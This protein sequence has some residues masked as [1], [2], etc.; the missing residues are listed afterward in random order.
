MNTIY[1]VSIIIVNYNTCQLLE[2]CISSIYRH[3]RNLNYE[4]IVVDNASTDDSI[5]MIQREFPEVKLISSPTNLGFGQANNLGVKQSQGK[6]LFFLNSDTLLIHNAI[7]IL[8]QFMIKNPKA[9][10]CGGNLYTQQMQ[11]A[12]SFYYLPSVWK[13]FKSL[14]CK[15]DITKNHNFT[16]HP[17][18]V[19][20]ITGADLMI[21]KDLFIKSGGFDP[22]FFMYYEESE[23]AWRIQKAGYLIYSVPQAK[24][25]HLQGMSSPAKKILNTHFMY[26]KFIYFD[27]IY[28]PHIPPVIKVFHLSKCLLGLAFY[29]I[30]RKKERRYYWRNKYKAI[31]EV[32]D[33]YTIQ[34]TNI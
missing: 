24:I 28:G 15:S 33:Q 2:A 30:K 21:A 12:H 4:I 9:G 18:I 26:S 22:A 23:L 20:Y 19:D 10:I 25:I 17:L 3:T 14:Y 6:Y 27:K 5:D 8:Y 31:Q 16:Q 29:S 11:P 13:E 1:Q 7:E 32:Y 34:K